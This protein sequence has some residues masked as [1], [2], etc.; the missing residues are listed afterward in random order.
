[1]CDQTAPIGRPIVVLKHS[2][3]RAGRATV[4]YN[5]S[6]FFL[7]NNPTMVG[8]GHAYRKLLQPIS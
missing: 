2:E 6:P 1:M 4:N 5:G 3:A 7:E 8:V